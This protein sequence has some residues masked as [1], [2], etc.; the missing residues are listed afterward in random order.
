MFF[1]RRPVTVYRLI[2]KETIEENMIRAAEKK[3]QLEA[4]VV[5][6]ESTYASLA[7]A[8]KSKK[9]QRAGQIVIVLCLRGGGL[10]FAAMCL[11]GFGVC[12]FFSSV[13]QRI[14]FE[15]TFLHSAKSLS[16]ITEKEE[17]EQMAASLLKEVLLHT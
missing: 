3:L 1:A 4:E 9:G 5:G 13:D 6:E 10:L 2:G 8:A 15:M 14:G 16:L 17:E 7:G 12:F 11:I